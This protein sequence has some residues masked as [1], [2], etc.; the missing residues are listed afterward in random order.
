M[1]AIRDYNPHLGYKDEVIPRNF[2]LVHSVCQRFAKTAAYL[3]MSYEDIYSEGCIGLVKAFNKY[4]PS[5]FDGKVT[6]FSTYAVPI[7]QGEILRYLR[8]YSGQLKVSRQ[9][10]DLARKIKLSNMVQE[11]PGV[12]AKSL[13][14]EIPI[15]KTAL[16]YLD[17]SI[18]SA[19]QPIQFKDNENASLHDIIPKNQDF[20]SVH[21]KEFIEALP[22]SQRKIVELRIAGKSQ[23]EIGEALGISQ[24]SA[25]RTLAKVKEKLVVYMNGESIASDINV[26]EVAEMK[27]GEKLEFTKETYLELKKKGLL[28][29]EIIRKCQITEGKF[30]YHKKKWESEAA[31]KK[32]PEKPKAKEEPQKGLMDAEESY[33]KEIQL[34]NAQLEQM[35]E[36]HVIELEKYKSL[37]DSY[38]SELTKADEQNEML[39]KLLKT[40]L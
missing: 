34:L 16:E 1:E 19:D 31:T 17:V 23:A 11:P 7:I 6:K 3:G 18:L 20:S 8:D 21:V 12:I 27:E 35:K 14:C 24:V 29:S 33:K 37:A 9:I 36:A 28:D 40:L 4:D 10:K 32:A 2:K 38:K 15:I 22:I 30:Y 25:S 39:R 13:G 26:R 5:K